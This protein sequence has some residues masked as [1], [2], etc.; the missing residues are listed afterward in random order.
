MTEGPELFRIFW[1]M[2]NASFTRLQV[3]ATA[4]LFG[5]FIVAFSFKVTA[6]SS[7]YVPGIARTGLYYERV[8]GKSIAVVANATS[9]LPNGTH[10]VDHLISLG[11]EVR[12]VWA[13]EH[14]FRGN[15]DAGEHVEDGKDPKTGIAIR[16]LYGKNKRPD[17]SWFD[18]IELVIYDIQDVGVRFYTYSTTLSYVLDACV[19]AGVPLMVMDRGNPNGHY[20]DGPILQPGFE[21]MVGLHPIPVVHGLTMGEYA[22]MVYGERWMP[23]LLHEKSRAQFQQAGGLQVI[24]CT[25]YSHD[26]IFNVF[27]TPPSPNLRSIE[28][29]WHYPSL[30]FFEGT[31]ISCGRGTPAPFTLYGA[32][33]LPKTKFE[34]SFTPRPDHGSKYPKF[35]EE[36]CWGKE[37]T[38]VK[39]DSIDW[40]H[41]F[42]VYKVWKEEQ[43]ESQQFF[44]NFFEKLAGSKDLQKALEDGATIDQWRA[45]YRNE[46]FTAYLDTRQGIL[47]Y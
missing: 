17:I 11:A 13:P 2:K 45:S 7:V 3:R 47:L 23:Q 24:T 37:L 44:N 22:K 31:P 16:S 46:S 8:Q 9:L 14:G 6:Q 10:T 33:W 41:L 29:I 26:Q 32:P 38:S 15:K 39:N 12:E 27:Q 36:Q 21:S 18:G 20:V 35:K 42:S 5:I 28:A 25:G 40:T 30:C 43:P 1:A 19:E 34:Y 4:A